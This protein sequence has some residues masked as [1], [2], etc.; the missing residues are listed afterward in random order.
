M[1]TD[2]LLRLIDLVYRTAL[3]VRAWEPFT[4][5]FSDALGS[6]ATGLAMVQQGGDDERGEVSIWSG[7]PE[8]A[9][10]FNEYY[11]PYHPYNDWVWEYFVPGR[12][13]LGQAMCADED[14]VKTRFYNEWMRPQ[15]IFHG[16]LI[17]CIG[18]PGSVV[19]VGTYRARSTGPFGDREVQFVRQLVPHMTRALEISRRIH[20]Q[21]RKAAT[22]AEILEYGPHA[23]VVTDARGAVRH[24]N[25][26]ARVILDRRDGLQLH[27]GALQAG[28]AADSRALRTL[29]GSAATAVTGEAGVRNYGGSLSVA[30]PSGRTPLRLI[31]FALRPSLDPTGMGAAERSV[32]L[33]IDDPE[34]ASICDENRL[35]AIYGLT[36]GQARLAVALAKGQSLAEAVEVLGVSMNTVKTHLRAIFDKTETRRQADLVRVL[37]SGLANLGRD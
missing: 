31:V 32:A 10:S 20:L 3:D 37:S 13:G 5:A 19:G 7:D 35:Q 25:D 17:P 28:R 36:P 14:V 6:V 9:K 8:Y 34:G 2:T 23:V 12:I 30:R 33:F 24:M 15:D 21:E 26:R 27:Q 11:Y 18:E 1:D 16:M 29:I 4:H 22:L